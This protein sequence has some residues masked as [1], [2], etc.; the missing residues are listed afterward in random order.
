M[1]P[2]ITIA[3]NQTDWSLR[4]TLVGWGGVDPKWAEIGENGPAQVLGS[5]MHG[6]IGN[7]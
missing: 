7:I 6:G 4:F 3:G 5:Q 1:A 2:C